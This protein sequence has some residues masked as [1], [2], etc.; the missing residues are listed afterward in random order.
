MEAIYTSMHN[1]EAEK[2]RTLKKFILLKEH[3]SPQITLLENQIEECLTAKASY[4]KFLVI[5]L[6]TVELATYAL[7]ALIS[8]KDS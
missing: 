7:C 3:L 2:E 8:V 6:S 4:D 1:I 5:D